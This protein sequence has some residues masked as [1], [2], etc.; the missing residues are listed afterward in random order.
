MKCEHPTHAIIRH[1]GYGTHCTT[2]PYFTGSQKDRDRETAG[3]K[4]GLSPIG[5]LGK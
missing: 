2:C 4:G 3:P 1:K 5:S